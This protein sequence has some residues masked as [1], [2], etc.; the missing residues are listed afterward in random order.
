[1]L[2]R[3]VYAQLLPVEV[4]CIAT[5]YLLQSEMSN[6]IVDVFKS[7]VSNFYNRR[8][9]TYPL[10]GFVCRVQICSARVEILGARISRTEGLCHFEKSR[11]WERRWRLLEFTTIKAEAF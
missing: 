10:S 4:F 11:N 2:E 6:G 3:C 7:K 1:M 5:K 8:R 9:K